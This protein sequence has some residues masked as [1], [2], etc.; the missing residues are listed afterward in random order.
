M[1]AR[2]AAAGA[3]V[4]VLTSATPWV[5]QAATASAG[6]STCTNN[7]TITAPLQ[8]SNGEVLCDSGTLTNKSTIT[9]VAGGSA[10][11]DAPTF[12]NEG[13]VSAPSGTAL[14]FTNAPANLS[15]GTLTGG[16]WAAAGTLSM[17]G[18]ITTLDAWLKLS[19]G[20]EIEDSTTSNNAVSSL[21]TITSKGTFILDQS[22]SPQ[23]GSVT[24]AGHIILGTRGDSS[25][26]VNWQDSGTFTMTGGTFTFLDGNAC[27]NVGPRAFNVTGG[28]ISGFGMVT[29]AVTVSGKAFF[30][31]T[32]GTAQAEFWLNGSYTQT[33]GTF[34][35][36][37]NDP[38]G[39]PSTGF[40]WVENG[41]VSLGGTLS[42]VSSG[43]RPAAGTQL[44]I[45]TGAPVSGHFSA[46]RNSGVA[47]FSE[48]AAGTNASLVAMSNSPPTAPWIGHAGA[49]GAGAATV[50]WLA[51]TFNG[52]QPVKG[53]AIRTLPACACKG[54]TAGATAKSS[55]VSGLRPGTTYTFVVVA[56]N[57]VGTGVAS[58][59]SNPVKIG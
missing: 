20:G 58:N 30:A 35:D 22:A 36:S 37:V 50:T 6:Q 56:T 1:I 4:L 33:G 21:S 39:T 10:T 19:G 16:K 46:I 2:V 3:I 32:L 15:H 28:T 26:A 43:A 24:S 8:L 55:V 5:A 38:S 48:Q 14:T 40:L 23:T 51:P 34:L 45:I 27:I 47:G 18:Q 44:S 7:L 54:L 57:S 25:D 42:V 12:V 9:V 31:P 52:G 13:M 29:G 59:P 49:A 11:I 53:Y 17:P 41:S